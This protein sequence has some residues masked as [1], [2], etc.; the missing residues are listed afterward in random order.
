M[1][2]IPGIA[3]DP[4]GRG[5]FD[6][7]LRP[8]GPPRRK[9]V[10]TPV[11]ADFLLAVLRHDDTAIDRWIDD[12][13]WSQDDVDLRFPALLCIAAKRMDIAQRFIDMGLHLNAE[14]A[15]FATQKLCAES[16]AL[17]GFLRRNKIPPDPESTGAAAEKFFSQSLADSIASAQQR[18]ADMPAILDRLPFVTAAVDGV[19]CQ[20]RDRHE[21]RDFFQSH[22]KRLAHDPSKTLSADSWLL[23]SRY[24]DSAHFTDDMLHQ[25]ARQSSL[26]R[27][28]K[29]ISHLFN[30][31]AAGRDA[32]AHGIKKFLCPAKIDDL[33]DAVAT[34]RCTLSPQD[35]VAVC[36]YLY[37]LHHTPHNGPSDRVESHLRKLRA[38]HVPR[39]GVS[40][41]PFLQDGNYSFARLLLETD[42]LRAPDFN[43]R[44]LI[45][46]PLSSRTEANTH[47]ALQVLLETVLPEKYCDRRGM[48][49]EFYYFAFLQ[50]W[51]GNTGFVEQLAT[52]RQPDGNRR[53]PPS[54]PRAGP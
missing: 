3:M 1:L 12:C 54:A 47:F 24:F 32:K 17:D 19:V 10:E 21:A 11:H 39:F 50:E 42:F 37:K 53:P 45:E 20:P 26:L 43:A 36:A 8:P 34:K 16:P 46:S 41:A 14:D 31:V 25:L 4:T 22:E 7:S 2:L 6:P 28:G 30:V 5:F 52:L 51:L 38:A 23:N 35:T 48:P 44:A 40:A 13:F 9:A 27:G 49:G 18:Q 15:A 29:E 33:V